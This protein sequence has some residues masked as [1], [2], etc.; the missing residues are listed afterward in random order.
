M[1]P[2]KDE[3]DYKSCVE[4]DCSCGSCYIGETKC[5]AE[6]RWKK[7]NNL[8]KSSEPSKQHQ[9]TT[10][11]QHQPLFYNGLSFQML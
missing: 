2:L 7:H 5:N 9:T 10:S 3:K 11:K 4:G 6:V 8:T 1:F